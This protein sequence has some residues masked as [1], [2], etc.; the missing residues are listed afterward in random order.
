ML[1]EKKTKGTVTVYTVDVDMNEDKMKDSIGKMLR[2][3]Q[4]PLI[5]KADSD[6]YNTKGELLLRFRK[7]KLK[8]TD[9][10]AFYDN[11]IKFAT[12]VNGTYLS[13]RI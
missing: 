10:N 8:Q 3:E 4:I 9:Q 2:R 6:V 7:N 5:I 12:T 1:I 11:V 13:K